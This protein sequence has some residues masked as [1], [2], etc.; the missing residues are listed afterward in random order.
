MLLLSVGSMWSCIICGAVDGGCRLKRPALSVLMMRIVRG[1]SRRLSLGWRMNECGNYV[2]WIKGRIEEQCLVLT[3]TP[4][5]GSR[6][7]VGWPF[8]L[9]CYCVGF[10]IRRSLSPNK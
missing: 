3:W 4:D 7:C 10:G 9:L 2:I 6:R 8:M 1:F 5:N